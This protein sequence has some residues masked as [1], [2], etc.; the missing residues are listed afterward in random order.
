TA[1][2][3]STSSSPSRRPTM[4]GALQPEPASRYAS[5]TSNSPAE[6]IDQVAQRRPSGDW[7]VVIGPSTWGRNSGGAL[8]TPAAGTPALLAAAA[9]RVAAKTTRTQERIARELRIAPPPFHEGVEGID[10]GEP[11]LEAGA[12]HLEPPERDLFACRIL[13]VDRHLPFV[14]GIEEQ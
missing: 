3:G 2:E 1:I 7:A 12:E 9:R 8:R 5:A 4:I 11:P 10:L 14:V 6:R 13:L